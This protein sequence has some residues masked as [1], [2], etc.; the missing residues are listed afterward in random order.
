MDEINSKEQEPLQSDR[1]KELKR[2]HGII[3]DK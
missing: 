2:C 1:M 3:N